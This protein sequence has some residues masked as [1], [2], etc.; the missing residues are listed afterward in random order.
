MMNIEISEKQLKTIKKLAQTVIDNTLND[1]RYLAENEWGLGEMDE[2]NEVESIEK[3]TIS[4]ITTHQRISVYVDIYVNNN[5]Y[6][7]DNV[8]SEI[9]HYLNEYFPNSVVLTND[10]KDDREF[11]PGID[12]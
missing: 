9:S 4:H 10:I 7:F 12:W 5:R 2:I 11:G 1:L 8:I 6:D 3:I